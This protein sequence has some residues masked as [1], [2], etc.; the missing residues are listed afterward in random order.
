MGQLLSLLS[1]SDKDV[2]DIFLDF[3]SMLFCFFVLFC[4]LLLLLL[5]LFFFFFWFFH[6]LIAIL[7]ILLGLTP[8]TVLVDTFLQMQSPNQRKKRRS[9]KKSTQY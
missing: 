8:S 3:E 1:N 6:L 2:V 5:L 7:L 4:L 9:T